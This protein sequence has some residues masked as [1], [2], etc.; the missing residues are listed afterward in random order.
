MAQVRAAALTNYFE[1]AQSLG[2]DPYR[3]LKRV[4]ISPSLLA[5]PEHRIPSL[6]AIRLLNDSAHESGCESF[7]LLMAEMRALAGLGAVGLLA[8]CQND[9]GE[10][11]ETVVCNQRFL[12]EVL[13][14][15]LVEGD[16]T[17]LRADTASEADVPLRQAREL[18]LGIFHR[19]LVTLFGSGWQPQAVHFLD[20]EPRDTSVHSRL[21]RC[22]LVFGSA[23]NGFQ[24][25]RE[26]LA[27]PN[28]AADPGL[29]RY[30]REY[31]EK[32]LAELPGRSLV[33]QAGETLRLLL[34]SGR[35]TLEQVAAQ[36]DQ[37]PRALQRILADAG[38][39]FAALLNE[40]RRDLAVRHLDEG[41]L[42]MAVIAE[43]L[44]YATPSSF[45]RWFFTE[46]GVAPAAWRAGARPGSAA[47]PAA[48]AA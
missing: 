15:E 3:M 11:I 22:P 40:V 43:R 35:G 39:S 48:S 5:D 28:P 31:L 14:F 20:P 12:S 18:T 1:V 8:R 7:G 37:Q 24:F 13:V 45:S 6:A 21:F 42:P 36:L 46:F 19:A 2:L 29:A 34:P 16:P 25:A 44:G 41:A 47:V 9:L 17:T 30:A 33:E 4:G 38:T 26:T 32:L 23:F 10:V 27:A